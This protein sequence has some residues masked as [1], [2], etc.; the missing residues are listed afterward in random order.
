[1]EALNE[2]LIQKRKQ[3]KPPTDY[4]TKEVLGK[5]KLSEEKSKNE[6]L[7]RDFKEALDYATV[8]TFSRSVPGS[9]E[10]KVVG[11]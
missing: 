2:Q 1:M 4:P 5:M 3:N 7:P 9:G 10:L 8:Y 11:N 6:D